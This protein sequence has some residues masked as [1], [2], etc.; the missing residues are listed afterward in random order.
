M[1]D[2]FERACKVRDA[3]GDHTRD[4]RLSDELRRHYGVREWNDRLD[5]E[6]EK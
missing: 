5:H 2:R 3:R 4:A 6:G 1:I